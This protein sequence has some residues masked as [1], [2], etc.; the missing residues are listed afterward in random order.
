MAPQEAGCPGR[1]GPPRRSA[2]GATARARRATRARTATARPARLLR[3]VSPSTCCS[4]STRTGAW[5]VAATS[6]RSSNSRR[7]GSR[8]RGGAGSS[9]RPP[10]TVVSPRRITRSPLAATTGSSRRSCANRSPM[11]TTRVGEC[12]VPTCAWRR[13]P[14]GIVSSS[15]STTS[16]R[17]EVGYA[18]AATSAAPRSTS[19]RSTPGRLTATRWPASARS[20]SRSCTCALR[21][22]TCRAPGSSTRSSSPPIDPDQSVPV[23]TVPIPRSEN[24]RST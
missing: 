9:T 14:S 2:L 22:R 15:S 11:R 19:R 21:T 18:P 1:W 7:A 23:T 6:P 24:E 12:A 4:D 17:Y 5:I 20:T 8:C 3:G 16:R 13:A 10:P